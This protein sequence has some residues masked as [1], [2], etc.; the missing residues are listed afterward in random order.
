MLGRGWHGGHA[1]SNGAGCDQEVYRGVPLLA[2]HQPGEGK[3]HSL[4]ASWHQTMFARTQA[5]CGGWVGPLVRGAGS[6]GHHPPTAG[7]L[8]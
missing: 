5:R 4:T 6:T 7:C 8:D 3:A 2:T 1:G